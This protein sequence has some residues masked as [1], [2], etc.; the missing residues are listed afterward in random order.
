M[1]SWGASQMTVH[2][3]RMELARR[4]HVLGT[5]N[6][7][8][9]GSLEGLLC[10]RSDESCIYACMSSRILL[11]EII[12]KK[13]GYFSYLCYLRKSCLLQLL[14]AYRTSNLSVNTTPKC[15][16]CQTCA[17]TGISQMVETSDREMRAFDRYCALMRAD[18]TNVR[19]LFIAS[20]EALEQEIAREPSEDGNR[21]LEECY[22]Y[23]PQWLLVM[24]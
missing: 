7:A 20:V 24:V 21:Q 19:V 5:V 16:Q 8:F 6:A 15:T 11:Q 3:Q 1:G 9:G 22:E 12:N 2:T 23:I 17:E 4:G 14:F 18:S 13:S 10:W